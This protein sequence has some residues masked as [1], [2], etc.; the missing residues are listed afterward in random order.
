MI[1]PGPFD[2]QLCHD[3]PLLPSPRLTTTTNRSIEVF[4]FL[5]YF[6]DIFS[7]ILILVVS[8]NTTQ[9]S[10]FTSI[11]EISFARRSPISPLYPAVG[12]FLPIPGTCFR[13]WR[14]PEIL[15]GAGGRFWDVVVI[16]VNIRKDR[17]G[18]DRQGRHLGSEH[19][20]HLDCRRCSKRQVRRIRNRS[21]RHRLEYR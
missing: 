4:L 13:I 15:L 6:Y 8:T 9:T 1:D 16:V 2:R 20:F 17:V 18:W 21:F 19:E 14:V 7:F 12:Q 3:D 10:T 5:F 11:K